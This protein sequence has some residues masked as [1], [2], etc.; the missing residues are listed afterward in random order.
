MPLP[1]RRPARVISTYK[2]PILTG[3]RQWIA[4]WRHPDERVC[5]HSLES[6]LD[7]SPNALAAP[8][9]SA[10]ASRRPK[11]RVTLHQGAVNSHCFES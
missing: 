4:R 9:V 2:H 11:I 6:D 5:N 10:I 3:D 8:V 1:Q 7:I